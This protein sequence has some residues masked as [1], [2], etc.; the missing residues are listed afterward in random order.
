M[1]QLHLGT[2]TVDLRLLHATSIRRQISLGMFQIVCICALACTRLENIRH[3]ELVR[4][5]PSSH[6][7][8]QISV[9]QIHY[10]D[11]TLTLSNEIF[12]VIQPHVDMSKSRPAVGI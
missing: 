6:H 3:P 5:T 9:M 1:V 2:K 10:W 7:V 11:T 12:F 8:N 4:N